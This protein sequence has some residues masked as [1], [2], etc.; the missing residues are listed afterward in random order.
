MKWMSGKWRRVVT[1]NQT[2]LLL[3]WPLAPMINVQ[4]RWYCHFLSWCRVASG[5]L[6]LSFDGTH[7]IRSGYQMCDHKTVKNWGGVELHWTLAW[8]NRYLVTPPF[9]YVVSELAWRVQRE[10]DWRKGEASTAL[11][12]VL[13][14]SSL[15]LVRKEW[16]NYLHKTLQCG[17]CVVFGG[18]LQV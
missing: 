6:E 7:L 8:D 5:Y 15:H 1:E 3:R 12:S 18:T 10:R 2:W 9:F 4:R 11:W 16:F 14:L 17:T 13:A